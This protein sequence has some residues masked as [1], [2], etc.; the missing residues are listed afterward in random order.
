MSIKQDKIN[1]TVIFLLRSENFLS[2]LEVKSQKYG[3]V[4]KKS[5]KESKNFDKLGRLLYR[6]KEITEKE[7]DSN[8]REFESTTSKL[9]KM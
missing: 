5:Q 1:K 7:L 2:E 9:S 6:L 8:M 4:C 3:E